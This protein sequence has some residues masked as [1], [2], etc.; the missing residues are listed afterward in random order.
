MQRSNRCRETEA[1]R[2]R[3]RLLPKRSAFDRFE[4]CI[5]GTVTGV[6]SETDVLPVDV[7]DRQQVVA[8]SNRITNSE[9]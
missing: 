7:H 6:D 3:G 2:F 4:N 8:N 9:F 1:E 5:V